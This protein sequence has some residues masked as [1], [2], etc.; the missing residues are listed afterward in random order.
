MTGGL[1]VLDDLIA[2]TPIGAGG[3]DAFEQFAGSDRRI[4][5]GCLHVRFGMCPVLLPARRSRGH[6]CILET[7]PMCNLD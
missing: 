4:T 7:R 6:G 2:G 3:L 5:S 1:S